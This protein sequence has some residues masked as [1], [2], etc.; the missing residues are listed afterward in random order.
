MEHTTPKRKLSPL[1]L[2]VIILLFLALTLCTGVFW[3]WYSGRSAMTQ[4][5]T[6]PELPVQETP[7]ESV[8]EDDGNYIHYS[9]K[10]YEYNQSMVNI[11][12]LGID[13]TELP[14]ENIVSQDQADV[15]VL[16]A[17]DQKNNK[18]TLINIPRDVMC[19]IDPSAGAEDSSG[20]IHAQLALSYALKSDPI[21]S[22]ELTRDTVSNLFFG[23]PIQGY[24]AYYMS[25]IGKLNDAVGGVT[26]TVIGDIDFAS[27]FVW[28]QQEDGKY[29]KVYWLNRLVDGSTITLTSDEVGPY[30]QYRAMDR[31]DANEMRMKRQKQYMLGLLSTAKNKFLSD[32]TSIFTMYDAVDDYL[33]TNMSLN[34]ISYLATIAA[35]MSLSEDIRTLSG[36]YVLNEATNSAELYVDQ[37]TLETLML[38]VFYTEVP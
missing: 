22:C 16:A 24:G 3:L 26:V 15:I 10:R 31:V 12:L 19:D 32:P 27:R 28:R 21:S 38:D 7:S 30:I 6:T 29:K 33:V 25:G 37:Q 36:E 2:A 17:L 9:G 20:L 8:P 18:I 35:K 23:L 1:L 11:L 34:S 4:T 5:D 14:G 13:S